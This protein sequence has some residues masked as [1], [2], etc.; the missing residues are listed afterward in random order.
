MR[1]AFFHLDHCIGAFLA[2]LMPRSLK[3]LRTRKLPITLSSEDGAF[4][5]GLAR[6]NRR[7]EGEILSAMW[8]MVCRSI[9]TGRS[10]TTGEKIEWMEPTPEWIEKAIKVGKW[11]NYSS[12]RQKAAR[13]VLEALVT[14]SAEEEDDEV[15]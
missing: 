7:S 10:P 5:S 13:A 2:T 9:R 4:L 14:S 8:A 12:D 15:A 6:C 1:F 11:G 3:G